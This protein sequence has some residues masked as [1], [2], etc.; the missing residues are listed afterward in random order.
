[1]EFKNTHDGIHRRVRNRIH[2]DSIEE[3]CMAFAYHAYPRS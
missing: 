1:M 2:E 3:G